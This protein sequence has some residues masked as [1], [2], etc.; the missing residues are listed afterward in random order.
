MS[1]RD[2]YPL[3]FD[4]KFI[5]GPCG[6]FVVVVKNEWGDEEFCTDPC[7]SLISAC[8]SAMGEVLPNEYVVDTLTLRLATVEAA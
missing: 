7:G 3:T 4:P 5:P 2:R 6:G 1:R 8:D